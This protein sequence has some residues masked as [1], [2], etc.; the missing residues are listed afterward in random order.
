M[1]RPTGEDPPTV[2]VTT[3]LVAVLLEFATEAD[4]RSVTVRLAVRPAREL[5][6]TDLDPDGPVFAEFYHP[7]AGRSVE[8]VFGVDVAVPPGQTPGLFVSHPTGPLAP[9][10]EDDMAERLFVAVPPWSPADLAVFTRGGRR[11]QLRRHDV[12]EA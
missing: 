1:T 7:E 4:P 2:H 12:V 10:T 11:C 6:L 9:R 3:G 8:A 5:G